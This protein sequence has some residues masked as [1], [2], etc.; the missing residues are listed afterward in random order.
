MIQVGMDEGAQCLVDGRG[1]QLAGHEQGFFLGA[2]L[3]DHVQEGMRIHQEEIFGPVLCVMRVKNLEQ[4][5]AII[6]HHS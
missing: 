3:F 4:A 5:L 6:N 1:F 2:T